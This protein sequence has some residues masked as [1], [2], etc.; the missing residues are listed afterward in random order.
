MTRKWRGIAVIAAIAAFAAVNAGQAFATETL[1]FTPQSNK[2]PVKNVTL[3]GGSLSIT[4]GQGESAFTVTCSSVTG[5]GEIT[6]AK[7][8][9]M[10]LHLKG[11]TRSGTSCVTEEKG[12]VV[13]SP[14]PVQLVYVSKER[15]EAALDFNYNEPKSP[16]KQFAKWV[17]GKIVAGGIRGAVIAPVTPVNTMGSAFAVKFV[18]GAVRGEQVPTK[19]QTESGESFEAFPEVNFFGTSYFKGSLADTLTLT[20]PE[21]EGKLEIKA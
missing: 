21:R 13:T 15:H 14:L 19:Y 11:C 6:H 17:C 1:S 9:T 3:T 10:T 12:E 18:E 16:V 8:A 5:E 4:E 2:Y 20:V 7:T